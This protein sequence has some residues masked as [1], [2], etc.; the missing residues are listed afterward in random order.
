MD[1][2]TIEKQYKWD[3]TQI[4]ESKKEFEQV[5]KEVKQQ[6]EEFTKHE[7]IMLESATN[8]YHTLKEYYDITRKLD[9][10]YV[11]TSLQ[12]DTDTANNQNQALKLK[13]QNLYDEWSKA[14]FFVTPTI[15]K[16]DN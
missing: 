9:K 10:L 7:Q 13:I 4:F 15:L 11:Y 6:I 2:E 1:R 8:L 14:S 3:L 12:F 16:K 5:F